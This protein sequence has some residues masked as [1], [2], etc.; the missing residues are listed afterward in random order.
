MHHITCFPISLLP[1]PTS[2]LPPLTSKP[3]PTLLPPSSHPSPTSL[4]SPP[5]SRTPNSQG[6]FPCSWTGPQPSTR[7]RERPREPPG[8]WGR[9]HTGW[10][11]GW[12]LSLSR[13]HFLYQHPIIRQYCGKG[14]SCH[15]AI[16]IFDYMKKCTYILWMCLLAPT[17]SHL[18]PTTSHTH[19]SS[20]HIIATLLSHHL[21][22]HAHYLTNLPHSS[23]IVPTSLTPPTSYQPPSLLPYHT[24][25][26]LQL[27]LAWVW[28]NCLHWGWVHNETNKSVPFEKTPHCDKYS[29]TYVLRLSLTTQK[30][31]YTYAN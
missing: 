11:P 21:W 8:W 15:V 5:T 6:F 13:G 18:P 9:S 16:I 30:T 25:P 19:C 10:S 14:S 4:L 31:T 26:L 23:H 24:N 1:P 27:K 29:N 28:L 7:H 20:F 17:T 3:S 22:L 12:P 2:Y